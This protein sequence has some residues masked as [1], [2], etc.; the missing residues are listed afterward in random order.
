MRGPYSG[1]GCLGEYLVPVNA[2]TPDIEVEFVEVRDEVVN[3]L[4]VKGVGDIR[5]ARLTQRWDPDRDQGVAR[6]L[7]LAPQ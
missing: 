6:A 7:S 5:C 4:S 2:N 3:S 1:L